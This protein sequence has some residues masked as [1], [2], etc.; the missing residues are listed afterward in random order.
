MKLKTQSGGSRAQ[1]RE[2]GGC[3]PGLPQQSHLGEVWNGLLEQLQPFAIDLRDLGAQSRDVASRT[4]KTR[5]KAGGDRVVR[6]HHDDGNRLGR[7][8]RCL[9][10]SPT[11]RDDHID[12]ETHELVREAR[13]LF[14]PSTRGSNLERDVLPFDVAQL[15]KSLPQRGAGVSGLIEA[16]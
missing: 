16:T 7:L 13:E 8:L 5:R 11:A 6:D 14:Q 10:G 2:K 1:R 3:R 4:R 9:N 15:A 12:L